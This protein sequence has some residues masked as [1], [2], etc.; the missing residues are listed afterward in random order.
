MI[1]FRYILTSILQS[2]TAVA[3]VLLLIV[4]SGRLASYLAQASTGELAPEL[5]FSIIL[6]RI[7]DFL[8]LIIPLALFVGTLLVY[9]RMY[10]DS[11]MIVM[12][13]AGVSRHTVFFY[14]LGPA[15]LVSVIVALLTLWA[16]P[17]SLVQVEERLE[18]AKNYHGLLFFREG[19]FQADRSG[20]N[21]VYVEKLPSKNSFEG[22]FVVEQ[23]PDNS[24]SLLIA[25][26]GSAASG[27]RPGF[28]ELEL[29]DGAI[30]EGSIGRN[31]FR[32]SRFASYRQKVYTGIEQE[33]VDLKTD[34]LPTLDLLD[35]DDTRE[36][37]AL[38]WRLS[39]PATVVVV[40]LLALAL[41][42][43]DRRRGRYLTML[44]AI[45]LYLVYLV[46]LSGTRSVMENGE[47]S[48]LALWLVHSA[49]LILALCLVYREEI[50]R[51]IVVA[52]SRRT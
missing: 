12:S 41:S 28:R 34:A 50:M 5:V 9:G 21:V 44:P 11:E 39:L 6:F 27:D 10:I 18:A 42:K 49:F 30:Y 1:I 40:S 20:G 24:M 23:K 36:R 52:R 47:V 22:V 13:A 51:P 19:K 3:I 2:T 46:S 43:T 25:R 45:A 48:M 29:F 26:N 33:R 17:A 32:V 16:A 38:H 35:S 31:D 7:P 4:T 15:M 8:P 14:T 37:A